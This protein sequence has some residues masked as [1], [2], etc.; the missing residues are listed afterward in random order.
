MVLRHLKER[1]RRPEKPSRLRCRLDCGRILLGEEASLQLADPIPAFRERQTW[2]TLQ[3]MFEPAL[4][5]LLIVEGAEL[6]RQAAQC[7]DQ[8]E[9]RGDDVDDQP[10]PRL[11]REVEPI[12]GFALHVTERISGREKI[13]VQVVA[14]VS[15]KGE[16]ADLVCGV[17]RQTHQISAGSDVPRPRHDEISEGH[18]GT[19]LEAMQSAFVHQIVAEPAE[20]ESGPVVAE[21]RS[22]D[23][24]KPNIGEARP[25]A[26]TML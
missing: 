7:P 26:V 23:H 1:W 10:E 8:P 3:V 24:T 2:I 15:R 13:G 9:L 6:W 17:K 5:K 21:V 16:V 19:S 12:L 22:E 25:V 20:S 11:A 18:V 4:V 14:A